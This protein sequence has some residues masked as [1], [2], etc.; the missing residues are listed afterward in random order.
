AAATASANAQAAADQAAKEQAAATA[1]ANA[2]AAADQAAK[3]RA[4]ATAAANAQAAKQS[5]EQ[6][7]THQQQPQLNVQPAPNQGDATAN[8]MN[9]LRSSKGLAPVQ[10]DAN[11]A[12]QARN[13][14]QQ[15]YNNGHQ[16]PAD[17]FHTGNE[18][19][20]MGFGAGSTVVQ[21]WYNETNM[22]G[23]PG[24]RNWLMNAGWSRV[25]FAQVGDVIVGL[26]G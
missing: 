16:I 26:A 13:R 4:A 21:A 20:A 24:H 9:Q 12:A 2:Q 14:A 5:S 19:I 8:A 10:W 22:I 11:L 7:A 3:E 6:A 1:S 18:V 25:G 17:H 23:A 15:I